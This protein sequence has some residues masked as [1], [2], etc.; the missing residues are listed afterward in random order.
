MRAGR[1]DQRI[2]IQRKARVTDAMGGFVETWSDLETVWAEVR[3]LSTREVWD[4]MRI[5]AET[6]MRARIR[7]RGDDA[8]APYYTSADRVA[9][10]GRTYG[11]ERVVEIGRRE[12]LEI[13]MVEGQAS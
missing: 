12:G 8:G 4:A 7:F 1:L 5:S 10:K 13:L 6:R 2:T 11:V 3:P 9:W